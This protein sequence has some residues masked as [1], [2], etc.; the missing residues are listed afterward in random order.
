MV[1]Y[2]EYMA[3]IDAFPSASMTEEHPA[4]KNEPILVSARS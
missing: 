2:E 3:A 4:E 1:Q